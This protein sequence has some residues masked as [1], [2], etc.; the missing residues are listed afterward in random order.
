MVLTR[1][2]EQRSSMGDLKGG[3]SA[4]PPPIWNSTVSYD[5]AAGI[6]IVLGAGGFVS[7][8]KG[9]SITVLRRDVIMCSDKFLLKQLVEE[10]GK[11]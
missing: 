7:D 3:H 1:P 10:I 2:C 8:F 9:N 5:I 11:T 6:P 4:R